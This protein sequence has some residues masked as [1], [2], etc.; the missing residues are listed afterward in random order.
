M[1]TAAQTTAVTDTLLT[2]DLGKYKS[3]R[4]FP[5]PSFRT[6][7]YRRTTTSTGLDGRMLH[8]AFVPNTEKT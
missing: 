7:H 3:P 2:I 1:L 8:L 6:G 5:P 4:A